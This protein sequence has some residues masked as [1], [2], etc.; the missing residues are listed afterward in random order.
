VL[1]TS[2]VISVESFMD[3]EIIPKRKITRMDGGSF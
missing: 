2:P 3:N 1:D